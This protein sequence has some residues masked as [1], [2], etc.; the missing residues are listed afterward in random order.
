MLNWN[1]LKEGKSKSMQKESTKRNMQA[2]HCELNG[3][4]FDSKGERDFYTKLVCAF[5][6]ASVNRSPTIVLTPSIAENCPDIKWTPDF[7]VRHNEINFFIEYKGSLRKTVFGNDIFMLK[8]SIVKSYFPENAKR[9]LCFVDD[10]FT[11]RWHVK[12]GVIPVPGVYQN[13]IHDAGSLLSLVD[14]ISVSSDS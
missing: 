14:S 11:P 6:L 12:A 8:W 5:G 3:I 13:R 1:A 9:Y 4:K 2:V 10:G 7:I